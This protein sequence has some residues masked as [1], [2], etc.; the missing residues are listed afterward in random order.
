[1]D[2]ERIVAASYWSRSG[3]QVDTPAPVIRY[4]RWSS[5]TR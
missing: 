3:A 1:M 5:T 2:E 4:G